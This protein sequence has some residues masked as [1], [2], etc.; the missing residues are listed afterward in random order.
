MKDVNIQTILSNYTNSDK[1][2][3][4]Q[5]IKLAYAAIGE[6]EVLAEAGQFHLNFELT[7]GAGASFGED[8]DASSDS[9]GN[10]PWGWN[11]SSQSC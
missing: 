1:E 2:K 3:A 6:A 10:R 9:E 5:L 11:A 8:W 4:D 7:Y